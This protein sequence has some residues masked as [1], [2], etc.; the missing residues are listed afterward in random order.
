MSVLKIKKNGMWENVSGTS[1]H[2][3]DKSD[4]TNFPESLPADGGD[5]DTV[6]GKH[7]RDFALAS[8]VNEMYQ[9]IANLVGDN[10]V[11]QQITDA[12]A[13]KSDI[14]HS[15]NIEDVKNLS[16][17]LGTK[18][19][20]P[21]TG[22]PKSD[23]NSSVQISLGKADTSIQSLD[24]YATESYVDT[25]VSSLV[26]SAPETLNTLNELAT[27]L[28]DDPNFATTV[29]SQIG[30][31][32]DK[33]NGKGLSTNDY[34][35]DE[36]A[37]LASVKTS[38]TTLNGLVGDK[39]VATQI[40]EAIKTKSDT[41]HTHLYAGSSSVG[42]AATSANKL[43]TNAGS[44]TQPVYF[45]NGV[46][47]KTTYTLGKSVPSDAKF[48]DTTY[49]AG[50]GISLSGNQ[51]SNA[52]VRSI[53]TGKTNGTISVNT[54]G[55]SA[56]V[57]VKGLGTAAYTDVSAYDAAGAATD[58]LD[59]AK[60][61]TDSK[62]SSMVGDE[63]VATQIANMSNNIQTQL[64]GKTQR[65]TLTGQLQT[66][67]YATSVIALC[68]A[69]QVQTTLNSYSIG[70]LTFQR[71]NA[72]IAPMIADVSFA[73]GWGVN[74]IQAR[75]ARTSAFNTFKPCI[76]TYNGKVYGGVEIV[77]N[78]SNMTEVVFDGVTT[79]NIFGLDIYKS[80][81]SE[82]LNEEVYNSISYDTIIINNGW[83]DGDYKFITEQ[84]IGSQ[85]VN[86][87]ASADSATKDGNGNVITETYA[88]K[89]H[90]HDTSDAGNVS[91]EHI[92]NT[93][94]HITSTERTN[95]NAAKTHANSAHAPSNAEKNQ[96]AFSNIAV[97][98][99]TTVAADSATDTV[100][101]VGSNVSITTNATSDTVTFSVASGSTS[102]KGVVQLTNSTSSTSTTTAATPA[103]VKSAYDLANTAN[104]TAASKANA[105][106]AHTVADITNLVD[107]IVEQ[108]VQGDWIYRKWNSGL[109][110]CWYSTTLPPE[111]T[112]H[113][114]DNFENM[115]VWYGVSPIF[116]V[117]FTDT[118]YVSVSASFVGLV[119]DACF[120]SPY[121][122]TKTQTG[123]R[124]FT[125]TSTAKSVY[126][127]VTAMGKW[128]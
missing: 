43:N 44:T 74:K 92:S 81:T 34:T 55:T 87:A 50:T 91:N 54:N 53:S 11:A 19:E 45:A 101:F 32:V 77:T 113:E 116:P 73:A 17:E 60:D 90:T 94:I 27:A 66:N 89:G 104:T 62:I 88:L 25:K 98:G 106:H 30:G 59:D 114:G 28:G 125:G 40:S 95:W 124:W 16:V 51:F 20:K 57:L 70:R 119:D 117:E 80:N 93:N 12:I 82:I 3:H 78:T 96:N 64:N 100:T 83:Q 102:A 108:C 76:F 86:H 122:V 126:L 79:F 84:N 103:A 63:S 52:G 4:I 5:A 33:E 21:T 72:S 23:L 111:D 22:I 75:V 99:Q 71:K 110:E 37:T 42:G 8:D 41:S 123:I 61:Y 105:S 121:N 68:D 38:V 2:T 1:G 35:N 15:H 67:S 7:A 10:S 118:P 115:Y 128:K 107:Y 120:G 48:T 112:M 69:P 26:D 18:Y 14:G 9:N 6:D 97:S 31:K 58:A 24:G 85:S 49:S 109:M 65:I 29:A 46:P 127:T 39:S 56:D 36:K 47:V 13:N